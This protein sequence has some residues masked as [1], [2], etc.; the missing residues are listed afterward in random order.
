[1]ARNNAEII[2]EIMLGQTRML[3]KMNAQLRTMNQNYTNL[4]KAQVKRVKIEKENNKTQEKAIEVAKNRGD[5]VSKLTKK[6]EKEGRAVDLFRKSTYDEFKVVTGQGNFISFLEYADLLLSSS[7]QNLKVFGVEVATARKIFYGFLPPGTFRLFNQISTGIRFISQSFRVMGDSGKEA[8]NIVTTL[9]KGFGKASGL[10]GLMDAEKKLKNID[11]V[12]ERLTEQNRL[13]EISPRYAYKAISN[14]QKRREKLV[15]KTGAKGFARLAVLG[16]MFEEGGSL[17]LRKGDRAERAKSTKQRF[18][19]IMKTLKIAAAA[20]WSIKTKGLK[21]FL[22]LG[23]MSLRFFLLFMLYASLAFIILKPI[24]PMLREA[25]SWAVTNLGWALGLLMD[26]LGTIFEGVFMVF[27]A[28]F[29][30]GTASDLLMG[31][32]TI[33]FGALKVLAGVGLALFGTG[34]ALLG[35]FAEGLLRSLKGW[36][37]SFF[38][39]W[40]GFFKSF[41]QL[42]IGAGLIYAL[43]TG[44]PLLLA[45]AIATAVYAA[46]QGLVGFKADGGKITTPMTVVGERGPEILVGKQGSNVIS[47]TNSKKALGGTVNNFNITINARDTSDAELRRIADKIGRMVNSKVTRSVSTTT[48]F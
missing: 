27:D 25:F 31:F 2:R 7:S 47:N 16:D 5:A 17:S 41:T 36:F 21:L 28:I 22:K 3:T 30:G 29:G 10:S 9:F 32:W 20:L 6:L 43:I 24:L 8:N 13:G 37:F 38:D 44:F 45:T 18:E 26:G 12:L 39:S 11:I 42:V 15:P 35:G 34:I 14:L 48:T 1:M 40:Q 33:A 23:A 46:V 19:R 4:Q